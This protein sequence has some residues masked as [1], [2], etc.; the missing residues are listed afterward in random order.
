MDRLIGIFLI[1]VAATSFATSPIFAR[2]AYGAGASPNTF[3]F[4][5]FLIAATVLTLIMVFRGLQWPRGRL[6]ASLVLIGGVC[7]AGLNLSFYTALTLAP[8]SLII[9]IA[10]M[11]PAL[12]TLL[13]ALFLKQPI[14]KQQFAALF[15]TLVGVVVTTGLDWG[16]QSLGIVLAITTAVIYSAYFTFGSLSIRKAGP[17]PASAVI[18]ISVTIVYGILVAIQGFKLPTALSGW[19]A[20]ILC[21]LFSTVFGIVCLYEGLKRV[22]P[23]NTAIVSTFEVVVAAVLAILILGETMS[24]SK[25]IGACMIIIAVTILGRGEYKTARGW[26]Q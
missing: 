26:I 17:F 19:T 2:I 20:I 5:R 3:L 12:V 1:I 16:G 24:M 9:V 25:I 4:I 8:V 15:L 18:F 11:Y 6:L 7:F 21:A 13:S 22:D 14:T 10:Y 23:A